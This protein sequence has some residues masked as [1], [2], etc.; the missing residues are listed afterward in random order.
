MFD[1][2]LNRLRTTVVA[3]SLL[4]AAVTIGVAS[5]DDGPGLA[6]RLRDL[7]PVVDSPMYQDPLLE[8]P[9]PL[10]AFSPKLKP[11]WLKAIARPEADVQRQA[12]DAVSRAQRMGMKGLTDCIPALVE[13]LDSPESHPVVRR[14][15]ARALAI[16]DA[17]TSAPSLL[18]H[19]STEGLAYA[20]FVEPALARWD[21]RPARK[22]WLE[23]LAEHRPR[24]GLLS[25]AIRGLA[26]VNEVGAA[27]QLEKLAADSSLAPQVRLEAAR[28]L[29]RLRSSGLYDRAKALAAD[30]SPRHLIDRLVAAHLLRRHRGG[31]VQTLLR[32]L[33]LD[34]EPAVSAVALERLLAVDPL[35]VLPIVDRLLPRRDANVRV[36]AA[37]A[38][39]AHP[40][41]SSI[42]KLGPLLNDPHPGNRAFVRESLRRFASKPKL[43]PLVRS[44]AMR[45]L[46]LDD[47]R[48]QEQAALLLGQLD[49]KPAAKRLVFLLDS[50]RPEVMQATAWALRKLAIPA[51]LPAMLAKA[52]R[53]TTGRRG[54][55]PA[56]SVEQVAQ[57]FQTFGQMKYT[58]AVPLLRRFI[59]KSAPFAIELRAAAIWALGFIDPGP[60]RAELARKLSGRLADAFGMF[61]EFPPVRRMSAVSL[62]RLKAKDQF[63]T[64]RRFYKNDGPQ[65]KIGLACRWAIREITGETLPGPTIYKAFQ[66]RWFL[67]PLE[68]DP[69][70]GK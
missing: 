24:R 2:P 36:L 55:P 43:D 38:L 4:G 60:Q 56:G 8:V 15:S 3:L 46:Q 47:W 44:E 34:R 26:A 21:Y 33:A 14:A 66:S 9:E 25:L 18:K 63:A 31:P 50:R 41:A 7:K 49:H 40:D 1:S 59:P 11:L 30:K 53:E 23:R 62:G 70:A 69:A 64:L 16:L 61:P 39:A 28:A 13:V 22:V 35:L 67:V 65:T 20:Q 52:T 5:A 17:R 6:A 19:L 48:G 51:T 58:A 45:V 42:E 27:P 54:M 68:P 29:G 10:I 57:L 32:E 37:S 12:A